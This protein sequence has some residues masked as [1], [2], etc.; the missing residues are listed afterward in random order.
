MMRSITLAVI[1]SLLLIASCKKTTTHYAQFYSMSYY[2]LADSYVLSAE[3]INN[4]TPVRLASNES[5]SFNGVPGTE[6]SAPE[7]YYIWTGKGKV[8]GSVILKRKKTEIKNDMS[9]ASLPDY[10]I[11][12][13]DTIDKTKNF[14]V[15]VK[16][17][18]IIPNLI[19]ITIS[20]SRTEM[21][22]GFTGDSVVYL[23]SHLKDLES[24]AGKVT[25]RYFYREPLQSV[26]DNQIG[27]R[28]YTV[29]SH[30]TVWIK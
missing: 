4:T 20:S 22:N 7:P 9:F 5:V 17:Y 16:N 12:C 28:H 3:Y 1:V 14:V 10:E 24:G 25:F 19:A 8:S 26:D 13:A 30:K 23:A 2:V 18:Q 27:Q 29:E 21:G 15:R 6:G 11:L